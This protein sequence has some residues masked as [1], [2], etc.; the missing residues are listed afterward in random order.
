MMPGN[1]GVKCVHFSRGGKMKNVMLLLS[2]LLLITPL[3][4]VEEGENGHYRSYKLAG[5]PNLNYNSDDG[6]GY[7]ARLDYF[8]YA[9]GGYSPYFYLVDVQLF[10]TTGGKREFWIFFDSPFVLKN[11]QRLT[12]EVRYAKFNNA[13][14]FGLGRTSDFIENLTDEDQPEFIN[15]DYYTF[16]RTRTSVRLDYQKKWRQAKILAGFN[17]NYTSIELNDGPTLLALHSDLVPVEDEFT[18]AVRL[19][20]I[21]DS[22][23]FEPAPERGIW[24]EALIEC[25]DKIIGSDY[26]FSRITL[27]HRHYYSLL[28]NVV[29]AQRF[30]YSNARGDFP[31]YER[32]F[33]SSSFR[34][35]EAGGGAKS[36]RGVLKNRIIGREWLLVN[37]EFRYKLYSFRA[38]KQDFDFSLSAFFDFGGAWEEN[39]TK[40]GNDLMAGQGGGLHVA[41]NKNFI[42][43]IDAAQGDEVG[44]GLYIGLGYLY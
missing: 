12:A 15:E 3:Q 10:A 14:Y 4:A 16:N 43:S 38:L 23:D 11:D 9:E 19:G 1:S 2:I 36:L 39:E 21:Y 37:S 35:E 7:G 18:N 28:K 25:F 24:S 13:P 8:R 31:F 27:T 5:L 22:R 29:F 32:Q 30:I 26:T 17:L 42:L 6:F 44:F 40:S 20:I 41:W 33:M 34:I